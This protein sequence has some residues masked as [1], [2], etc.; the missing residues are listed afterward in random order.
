MLVA[1]EAL[2]L[3]GLP[4]KVPVK[5]LQ[6]K[7]VAAYPHPRHCPANVRSDENTRCL[8]GKAGQGVLVVLKCP[9]IYRTACYSMKCLRTTWWLRDILFEALPIYGVIKVPGA[10]KTQVPIMLKHAAAVN[11]AMPLSE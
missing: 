4:S 9:A 10:C 7:L 3:Q 11:S 1:I 8:Q 5:L 2:I 6:H